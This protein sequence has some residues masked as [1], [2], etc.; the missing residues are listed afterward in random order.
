MKKF[1]GLLSIADAELLEAY[2]AKSHAILEF[3]MGGSTHI[4]AQCLRDGDRL[5][6]VETRPE[7]IVLTQKR[8][9]KLGATKGVALLQDAAWQA[10]PTPGPFDLVFIDG[11]APRR[12]PFALD[13]WRRLSIGGWLLFHDTR[14]RRDRDI[15]NA[16][17]FIRTTLDEVDEVRLNEKS[18]G[19][20][21]NL[22]AIRRKKAEPWVNWPKTEGKPAWAYGDGEP[23]ESFWRS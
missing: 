23:P 12:L 11:A 10:K 20:T 3:G 17:R 5:V 19:R 9:H 22:T 7:W 1:V 16:L 4:F 21:S 6:S 15:D 14:N 13:A 8:L 2:A 18:G